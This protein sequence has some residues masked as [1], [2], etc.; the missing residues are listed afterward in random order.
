MAEAS[1]SWNDHPSTA[2]SGTSLTSADASSCLSAALGSC[3]R[4][5]PHSQLVALRDAEYADDLEIESAMATWSESSV[6]AFFESG[7]TVRPP[8]TFDELAAQADAA[9][10]AGRVSAATAAYNDAAA[11]LNPAFAVSEQAVRVKLAACHFVAGEWNDV[12]CAVECALAAGAKPRPAGAAAPPLAEELRFFTLQSVAHAVYAGAGAAM[13]LLSL[14]IAR[15]QK[16]TADA[17]QLLPL[18]L[19]HVRAAPSSLG[20]REQALLD[21]AALLGAQARRRPTATAI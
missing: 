2:W 1:S 13:G 12:I 4:Q 18:L 10:A 7:G 14:A 9:A 17:A 5:V 16:A 21:V 3:R 6:S 8:C 15:V 20:P 11:V 19:R